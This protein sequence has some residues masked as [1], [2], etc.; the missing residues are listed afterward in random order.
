MMMMKLNLWLMRTVVHCR[1]VLQEID[2][3]SFKFCYK[4]TSL[5][6]NYL[7]NQKPKIDLQVLS[8]SDLAVLGDPVPQHRQH[9]HGRR[10]AGDGHLAPGRLSERV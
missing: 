4:Y 2:L 5:R 3:L 6:I 7:S 10:R 9:P 1:K 8:I